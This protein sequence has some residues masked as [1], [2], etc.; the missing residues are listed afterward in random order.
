MYRHKEQFTT[1]EVAKICN[2][3][4]ATVQKY[5]DEGKIESCKTPVTKQ[6]RIARSALIQFMRKFDIPVDQEFFTPIR[7]LIIDDL[8]AT[9]GTISATIKLVEKLGGKVVECAFLVELP[10]LKGREQMKGYN[11]FTLVEFEGE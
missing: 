7:V 3:T 2:M 10:D 8:I 11:I 9:G 6:R 1:G 5:C 4:I